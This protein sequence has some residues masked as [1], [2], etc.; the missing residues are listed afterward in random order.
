MANVAASATASSHFQ[1]RDGSRFDCTGPAAGDEA[2]V[3][4][5][6]ARKG[7]ADHE[8]FGQRWSGRSGNTDGRGGSAP[9]M[10][11]QFATGNSM[12]TGDHRTICRRPGLCCGTDIRFALITVSGLCH[13]YLCLRAM[14]SFRSRVKPERRCAKDP[15]VSQ[16][17]TPR[18]IS[19]SCV[20]S[21]CRGHQKPNEM[22][23]LPG[24]RASAFPVS[25]P[26][27]GENCSCRSGRLVKESSQCKPPAADRSCQTEFR[28]WNWLYQS[29]KPRFRLPNPLYQSG[30]PQSS[31]RNRLYQSGKPQS[32]RRNRLYQSC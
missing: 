32:P 10:R 12:M 25:L 16:A 4:T 19:H 20:R 31:R 14:S 27:G 8:S 11:L 29:C 6:G 18:S 7:R 26:P 24:V 28:A 9:G 21:G 5:M 17:I 2:W 1:R 22:R 30:K 3:F 23:R 13:F 15:S